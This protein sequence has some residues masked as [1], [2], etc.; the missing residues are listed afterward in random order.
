MSPASVGSCT[1]MRIRAAFNGG[2]P[3]YRQLP[4]RQERGTLSSARSAVAASA[5]CSWWSLTMATGAEA[6]MRLSV[7]V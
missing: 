1:H 5:L 6:A 4:A 2:P 3:I 7:A